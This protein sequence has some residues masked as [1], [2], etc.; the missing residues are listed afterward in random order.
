MKP[1]VIVLS[2]DDDDTFHWLSDGWF[3]EKVR[4]TPEAQATMA[5][6]TKIIDAGSDVPD[7]I[8]RLKAAGFVVTRNLSSKVRARKGRRAE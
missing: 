2:A 5:Q 4:A 1:G 8:A 7:V 3:C 6:V